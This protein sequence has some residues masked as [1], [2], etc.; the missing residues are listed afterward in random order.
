[1][2]IQMLVVSETQLICNVIK[3]VVENQTNI[4]VIGSATQVSD[5]L[6]YVAQERCNMVLVHSQL[7]KNGA[8]SFVQSLAITYP[9]LKTVVFDLPKSRQVILPYLEG[10][11]SGYILR[12]DS[13]TEMVKKIN[14]THAGQPVICPEITAALM[15]RVAELADYRQGPA[16]NIQTLTELTRR[17]REVLELLGQD[18]SNR[19]IA[20][21]LVI[22]VGTVKNHVHSILKKLDVNSRRDAIAYLPVLQS[23]KDG[24]SFYAATIRTGLQLSTI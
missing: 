21:E 10:G 13:V 17:E 2:N 16:L 11:A 19:E 5:A 9:R 3:H 22:E 14:A 18:L 24:F 20:H 1:M 15:N 7:S 8:L 23:F 4:E 12:D 6:E